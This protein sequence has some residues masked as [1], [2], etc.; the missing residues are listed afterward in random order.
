MLRKMVGEQRGRNKQA[1]GDSEPF[2]GHRCEEG[3]YAEGVPRSW[4]HFSM[5][6]CHPGVAYKVMKLAALVP[7]I[8]ALLDLAQGL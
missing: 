2:S 5:T 3:P 6:G 7:R 4:G 1:A 8:P